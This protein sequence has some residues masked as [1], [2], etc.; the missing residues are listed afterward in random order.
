MS[1]NDSADPSKTAEEQSIDANNV[2]FWRLSQQMSDEDNIEQDGG[3]DEHDGGD[4]H[5]SGDDG[6]IGVGE[7]D[8]TTDGGDH[9]DGGARTDGGSSDPTAKKKKK[10]RKDRMPQVFAPF[11]E[12]FTKKWPTRGA[13]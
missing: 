10:E 9:T 4:E 2:S 12:E 7:D 8:T 6:G 11:C 13:Y 3:D 5:D 1:G